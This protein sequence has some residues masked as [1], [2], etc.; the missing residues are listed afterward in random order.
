M[1]AAPA[2]ARQAKSLLKH[3]VGST[4]V[5]D[6]VHVHANSAPTP[7]DPEVPEPTPLTR[8]ALMGMLNAKVPWDDNFH[9]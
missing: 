6:D 7:V 2:S 9:I 4:V 3:G 1:F 8:T 5:L